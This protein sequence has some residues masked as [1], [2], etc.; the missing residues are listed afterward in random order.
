MYFSRLIAAGLSDGHVLEDV[1][2][3]TTLG[4]VSCASPVI[5]SF[6]K[7]WYYA[8]PDINGLLPAPPHWVPKSSGSPSDRE[9]ELRRSYIAYDWV[10]R[11]YLPAIFDLVPAFAGPAAEFRALPEIADM[12]GIRQQYNKIMHDVLLSM[13]LIPFGSLMGQV[14]PLA[15][16]VSFR[17]GFASAFFVACD[18]VDDD[19]MAGDFMAA[20]FGLRNAAM[21]SETIVSMMDTAGRDSDY[22]L[23]VAVG[24]IQASA[25]DLL[26][27]MLLLGRQEK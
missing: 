13:D 18:V 2:M 3:T 19:S 22:R 21:V 16:A 7:V 1:G 25:I 11:V 17:S 14:T 15:E 10:A 4:G 26:D 27:R 24:Q 5:S 23:F 12:Q 8:L 6:L 20:R 9:T